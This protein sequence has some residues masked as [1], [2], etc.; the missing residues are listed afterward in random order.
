MHSYDC[1]DFS[2]LLGI[3]Y[4]LQPKFKKKKFRAVFGLLNRNLRSKF[5]F[6]YLIEEGEPIFE[7]RDS[8]FKAVMVIL[9]IFE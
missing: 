8:Y 4:S 3:Y 2:T 9:S 6:F 5:T 7:F 1:Y